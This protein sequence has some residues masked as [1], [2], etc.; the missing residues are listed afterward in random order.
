MGP[1]LRGSDLMLDGVA[2]VI[3]R[4]PFPENDSAYV[5]VGVIQIT[6]DI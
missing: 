2:E 6:P 5:W 1:I 4:V 3:L